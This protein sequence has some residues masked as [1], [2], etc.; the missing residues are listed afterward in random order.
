MEFNEKGICRLAIVPVRSEPSDKAE[1]TTQLLFGEHYNVIDFSS[2]RKW[3]KVVLDYDDYEG[4]IDYKQHTSISGEYF[5]HLNNIDFKICTDTCSTILY[6]KQLIQIVLGSIL[7]ITNIELF[8]VSG[9]FAF[10]GASKSISEKMGFDFLKLIA[11]KFMNA[12]YLWGGKTPFGT[13]CSGF[14]QQLFR[15]CGYRLKRDAYQQYMQGMLVESMNDALPGDLA[16]FKN[17]D[18][19]ISHVGVLMEDQDFIHA[20]GYVRKDKLDSK[21]I[22]NEELSL[23]THHLVG[24]RRILKT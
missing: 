1:M 6:K 13:D 12:P 9:Q 4:W 14:T 18:D 5:D 3:V 16:F 11:G 22:F 2:D 24:I 15:V 19:R 8:E 7:P 17:T 10:N 20:S 23:Y 21:G